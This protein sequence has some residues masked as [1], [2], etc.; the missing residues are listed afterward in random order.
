MVV[1]AYA[2]TP[3]NI[4]RVARIVLEHNQYCKGLSLDWIVSE[5]NFICG[6]A[7]RRYRSTGEWEGYF[8]E[9]GVIF[10]LYFDPIGQRAI[11]LSIDPRILE[12]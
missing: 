11:K 9:M 1:R 12:K 10:S 8:R 2:G 6:E 4:V 7:N 5:I 3:D